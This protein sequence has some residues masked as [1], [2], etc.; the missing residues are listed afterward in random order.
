MQSTWIDLQ[1]IQLEVLLLRFARLF[2]P[3]SLIEKKFTLKNKVWKL[4]VCFSYLYVT[5]GMFKYLWVR[6]CAIIEERAE[7][8]EHFKLCFYLQPSSSSSNFLLPAIWNGL[9]PISDLFHSSIKFSTWSS[10]K[11]GWMEEIFLLKI[12]N[13]CWI[14]STKYTITVVL[15]H[16]DM[17]WYRLSSN[18]RIF[19]SRNV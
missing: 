15:L 5:Y 7:D 14:D 4:Y 13:T 6:W 10:N 3:N 12:K 2:L 9:N 11:I 18:I 1:D 16:I 17:F 8:G 19:I